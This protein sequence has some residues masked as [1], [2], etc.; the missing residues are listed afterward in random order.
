MGQGRPQDKK[1]GQFTSLQQRSREPGKEV[2]GL[3]RVV[4]LAATKAEE[5]QL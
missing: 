5:L 2:S 3:E 1:N 4:S